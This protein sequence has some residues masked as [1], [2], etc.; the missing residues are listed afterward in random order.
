[1][2]YTATVKGS[3]GN[4]QPTGSVAFSGTPLTGSPVTVTIVAGGCTFTGNG[5]GRVYTCVV[6][7]GAIVVP[8][9]TAPGAYTVT[10]K[11]SGSTT[12]NST[13]GT[14]TETV[15]KQTPTLSTPTVTPNTQP[16]GSVGPVVLTTTFAWLGTGLAPTG[17]VTFTVTAANVGTATCTAPVSD[18]ET[19]TLNYNP[20]A[21]TVGPTQSCAPYPGDTNY[22]A[23]NSG[24]GT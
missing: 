10:A 14:V 16:Q 6:P 7:S 22:N 24:N 9:L 11:Y 4:G 2:T 8:V 5:G 19:C 12:Y 17:A 21:L 15:A 3:A 13:S 20:S 1:M 18:S 23:V